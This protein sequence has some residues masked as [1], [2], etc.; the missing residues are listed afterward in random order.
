MGQ[1]LSSWERVS[2]KA[3][4]FL[5]TKTKSRDVL[6]KLLKSKKTSND[7]KTKLKKYFKEIRIIFDTNN[8]KTA[9]KD[10]EE[11][12]KCFDHILHVLQRFITK[13]LFPNLN[14]LTQ[15]MHN[16]KIDT[17]F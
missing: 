14:R 5:V 1:K 15:F 16:P 17:N 9:I 6:Y 13:K 3:L 2:S 10:L 7:E 11:L 12:L 4:Y 8:Y